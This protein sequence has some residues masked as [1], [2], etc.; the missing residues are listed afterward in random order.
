MSDIVVIVCYTSII[1]KEI[2]ET[3]TSNRTQQNIH[4]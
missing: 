3:K 1:V 2:N 4:L